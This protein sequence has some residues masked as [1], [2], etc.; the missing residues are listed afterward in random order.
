[1]RAWH[2]ALL[3]NAP[4]PRRAV[5]M[6][7]RQAEAIPAKGEAV[8]KDAAAAP[9]PNRVHKP[10]HRKSTAATSFVGD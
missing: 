7:Q 1:M 2:Q 4:P 6:V 3:L 9:P 8:V 10:L 5:P